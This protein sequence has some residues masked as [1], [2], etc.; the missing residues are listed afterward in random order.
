MRIIDAFGSAC[1]DDRTI[2]IERNGKLWM[3]ELLHH[4]GVDVRWTCIGDAEK[5]IDGLSEDVEQT[6]DH[7]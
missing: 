4:K 1:R 3:L 2:L 5:C 7:S 6:R